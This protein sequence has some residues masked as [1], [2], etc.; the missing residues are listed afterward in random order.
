VSTEQAVTTSCQR[1]SLCRLCKERL[2][3]ERQASLAEAA[4]GFKFWETK[5]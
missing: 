1:K 4:K 2:E 5:T 3:K